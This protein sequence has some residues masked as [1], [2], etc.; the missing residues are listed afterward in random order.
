MPVYVDQDHWSKIVVN[1]LSNAFKFTFAG[2]VTVVVDQHDGRAR[3]RVSDTGEGIDSSELPKLFDRFHRVRGVRSRSHE[4]SGIGLALVDQLARLHGGE[5]TV[6]SAPGVGTTFTVTL[7]LGRDHLPSDRVVDVPADVAGMQ[8]RRVE[9]VATDTAWSVAAPVGPVPS[10][11]TPAGARVLVVDDNADMR[12]YVAGLLR[13]DGYEVATAG[14]GVEALEHLGR[15]GADLVLTDVMMPRLDGFGLLSALRANPVTVML[16]VVMMSARAGEEGTLE[17]LGAGA[18]DYLVKPFSSR[19]LV[20]RVRTNLALDR[21]GRVQEVLERGKELLDQAQR[22]A[23]VG[24]WEVDLDRDTLVA[25]DAFL[26]MLEL[27]HEDVVRLGASHVIASRVHA[28]DL[29]RVTE[30]LES[31]P[32]GEEIAF[33]TRIRLPSGRERLFAAR[34]EYAPHAPLG[35]RVLRGSFQDITEQRLTQERLIAAEAAHEAAVREREIAD[36]LQRALLP[37]EKI[38]VELLDV[39]TYYR[40]GAAGARVGGDWFDVIDLGAGGVALVIG[41]VMGRGVRA[42]AVTGQLRSAVRALV[43]LD[44]GPA[45]VLEQLDGIVDDL[46]EE[47]IVT[48][49][50]GVVEA[51]GLTFRY[52]SAGHPPLV[53]TGRESSRLLD[54]S[55]PPLGAGFFG[56]E[57]TE[58]TIE[59]GDVIA[60]YTDGLVERRGSDLLDDIDNLA[61]E[62]RRVHGAP[63]AEQADAVLAARARR[64]GVIDDDVALL[65]AE[66]KDPEVGHVLRLRL[67]HGGTAPAHARASVGSHLTECGVPDSVRDDVVLAVSELVTNAVL[68]ARPPFHLRAA[69]SDKEVLV[70]VTDRTLLRP[71]RQRPDDDDEHGRGLNIVQV[72]ATSWGTRRAE[73]GKAVWCAFAL[74]G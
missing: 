50:I 66:V 16:P 56:A 11:V 40:A 32:A 65:V 43:R 10:G 8:A 52:A 5:V 38:D 44:L 41:D 23:G 21:A 63:V 36:A 59:P 73:A 33:E 54:C 28:D 35:A 62:L 3:L 57:D 64:G 37:E 68:H 24:S 42:A 74:D 45:E 22:L 47:Q 13:A 55:G 9:R 14:D 34:G 71:R 25:S 6:T 19:E 58:V 27:T 70:E 4:G 46:A 48:C 51:T 61:A 72:L 30:T 53:L 26:E 2:S 67:E 31:A 49:A 18:D 60:L 39:A 69:C 1:L 7:P 29:D 17:G 15:A 20:A 12:A